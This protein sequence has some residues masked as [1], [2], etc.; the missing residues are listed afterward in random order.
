MAPPKQPKRNRPDD[1]DSDDV[2]SFSNDNGQMMDLL[3]SL[4]SKMDLLSGTM[5]D[6]DNRLNARMDGLESSLLK[7]VGDVKEDMDKKF[8]SFSVDIDRR[9]KDITAS[10]NQKCE[11]TVGRVST[12][13][14]N[15]MDEMNALYEFKVDKLERH[16]LE[17]ELIITGVPMETNDNPFG[18]IGDIISALNCN[19]QERDFVAA[20]RVKRNGVASG[21]S[22][23][24][25]VRVYD[26]YVKQ[27]LLSSYF[28]HKNLNLK[29]IGFKTSAR[30]FINESLTKLNREI[31]NLASVAKKA[32]HI[33]KM[34]TR[35]GL[36]YVQRNGNDKPVCMQ[37]INELIQLLPPNFECTP[38]NPLLT[39]RRRNHSRHQTN[40]SANSA[41][42]L[43]P[44]TTHLDLNDNNN[45]AS[46]TRI[47]I[48][49]P[50]PADD[51]VIDAPI[52]KSN[53]P[54]NPT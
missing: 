23:P 27:E 3:Q 34:F 30:I 28:K 14:S 15:R 37:H 17:R 18:V 12:E 26:N 52:N 33:V 16:S 43:S 8:S 20:Y 21:R 49:D 46:V 48:S 36:V 31:F 22:V 41:S 25:I 42:N 32:N 39:T 54:S 45:D 35:S 53:S 44:F 4:S 24:I 7:M 47:P 38:S 19:L 51:I 1:A 50:L 2:H 29:D 11:D 6:I 5:A 10:S 9:L 13:F 40:P